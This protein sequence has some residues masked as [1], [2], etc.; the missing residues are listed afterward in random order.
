MF[1][2]SPQKMALLSACSVGLFFVT[3]TFGL[4]KVS[5]R[6]DARVVTE[7]TDLVSRHLDSAANA[8]VVTAVDYNNWDVG[9]QNLVDGDLGAFFDN[10][11]G[12]VESGDVFDSIHILNG[13]GHRAAYWDAAT[14]EQPIFDDIDP[15]LLAA[16]AATRRADPLAPNTA[17]H[18]YTVIDAKPQLH[19][20][21]HVLPDTAALLDAV[22]IADAPLSIMTRDI[23][24]AFVDK[25][26]TDL[27]LADVT[28]TA[29][30]LPGRT[31]Y[32]IRSVEGAPIAYVN[33]ISPRPGSDLVRQFL[34]LLIVLS[35]AFI[36][37]SIIIAVINHR[38][39]VALRSREMSAN[40][41]ARTDAL[42]GIPNRMAFAE[43][44]DAQIHAAADTVAL[45]YL[46]LNDFKRINDAFGHEVG[47]AVIVEVSRRLAAIARLDVQ[48]ARMGGD[49]FSVL[50]TDGQDIRARCHDVLTRLEDALQPALYVQ[51]NTFN[52]TASIGIAVKDSRACGPSELLRRA[53]V[54]M[55]H[56]KR[57]GLAT[58]TFYHL[59]IE[60]ASNDDLIV[61]Q[62]LR[63][64]LERPEEF[65][66]LFQPIICAKTG[67]M[68][69]AEALARWRSATLGDVPPDRFI[70]I[71]ER[72]GLIGPLGL[73]LLG[74]TC[75]LLADV[76]Q[77]SISVNLSPLQLRDDRFLTEVGRIVDGFGIA[78]QRIEFELTEGIIVDNRQLARDRLHSMKQI[79]FGTALDDFGT[80]FSSIGYLRQMPFDSLKIDRSFLV[81]HG[82]DAR[83]LGLIRS[84]IL[85]GQSLGQ[86]VIC[87]GVETADQADILRDLG[88]DM[89]QGYHFDR[90]LPIDTLAETYLGASVPRARRTVVA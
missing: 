11:A 57:N 55:Y 81:E 47:D 36:A 41:A 45:I 28:I 56:G 63:E 72:A 37:I 24:A 29:A 25:M 77:L 21:A 59:D 89:M 16:V 2:N 3:L 6:M 34:P 69:K 74:Q 53:D 50:L 60:R 52:V 51:Q 18:F 44:M 58:A 27:M 39:A 66:I 75:A 79:G 7:S 49:E 90:P 1:E 10:Y 88:C 8:L 48:V 87:E 17:A 54:A 67:L 46:D 15:A 30:P 65:T 83:N 85:M 26:S 73:I 82:M 70:D 14:A 62:A 12:G 71:A 9:Y 22:T 86:V 5:S 80:G 32:V 20:V 76:P 35:V 64:A 78:P 40:R 13:F 31:H 19:A 43:H 84:V 23:D 68:I 38:T 61:E 42:T 4:N 33:W